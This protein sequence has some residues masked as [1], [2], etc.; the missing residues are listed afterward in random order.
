MLYKNIVLKDNP[1]GFWTLDE[2]SGSIAYDY[3]GAQNHASYNF[4]PVNRYLPLVP[5]GVLGTKISGTDKITLSDLKSPYGNYIQGALADKYSSDVSFTLECWVQINECTSATIFADETNSIGIYWQNN[6]IVFSIGTSNKIHYLVKDKY[7]SLHI[8]G[9]YT[10]NYMSLYVDGQLIDTNDM[11][12][13]V[14]TN[15]TFRPQI[16]TVVGGADAYMI[17]DAPAVYRYELSSHSI[18]THYS[19]ANIPSYVSISD[20]ENGKCFSNID[21]TSLLSLKYEYGYNRDIQL[22]QNDSLYYNP[23]NKTISIF[24]TDTPESITTEVI[25]IISIP[26]ML[27]FVSS[28]IEWSTDNGVS[29]YTSS[30]GETNSY[31]E[32]QNGFPIPQYQYNSLDASNLI[33][34]KVVYSTADSSKYTPVLDKLNITLYGTLEVTSSNSVATISSSSNIS[35]GSES[36]PAIARNKRSGI[37]TGGNNSFTISDTEET[38]TI[39]MIYTPETINAA[40]LVSRGSNFISWNQAGAITKSGFDS[41][42]INGSLVSWSSNIWTYLTKNQPSHIVAIFTSP[43]SDNLVFNNQGIAAKYE[44]ISLYPSSIAISP[45]AHY[46]MHIGSY[47]ENISNESITVTEIGTPIYD[48]DFVVVKTV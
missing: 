30:T 43:S 28:K 9:V 2:S 7:K 18:T 3:S 12:D 33:Y 8:V 41:L 42:Y 15:S 44:G 22:L 6:S 16:G 24:K 4:T 29:V 1:I 19:M 23:S 46:A 39:E 47:Y 32:C 13:F 45:S 5:G 25:D 11:S 35:I 10:N 20:P 14:F 48:Y 38:K 36:S 40:S 34:L 37:R 31:V 21:G 26:I 27:D 17:I